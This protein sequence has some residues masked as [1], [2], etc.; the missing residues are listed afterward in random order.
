MPLQSLEIQAQ[1]I[2]IF[3]VYLRNFKCDSQSCCVL[4]VEQAWIQNHVFTNF[5]LRTLQPYHKAQFDE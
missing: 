2:S 4:L 1:V 3:C 5:D